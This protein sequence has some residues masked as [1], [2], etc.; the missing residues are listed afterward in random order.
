MHQAAVDAAAAQLCPRAHENAA[1]ALLGVRPRTWRMRGMVLSA[2]GPTTLTSTGTSRQATTCRGRWGRQVGRAG[3]VRPNMQCEGAAALGRPQVPKASAACCAV[4][5]SSCRL[6]LIQSRLLPRHHECAGSW[7]AVC[8]AADAAR[9]C[10]KRRR[11]SSAA[12]RCHCS[13]RRAAAA[14]TSSSHSSR[15]L[16]PHHLD[17]PAAAHHAGAPAAGLHRH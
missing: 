6:R 7:L 2:M 10:S 14:A 9:R 1:A 16:M 13:N 11:G 4:G 12:A 3:G 8:F 17:A 5:C 15:P